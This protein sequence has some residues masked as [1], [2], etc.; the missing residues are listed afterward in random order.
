MSFKGWSFLFLVSSVVAFAD[1]TEARFVSAIQFAVQ[2]ASPELIQRSQGLVRSQFAQNLE[3]LPAFRGMPVEVRTFGNEIVFYLVTPSDVAVPMQYAVSSAIQELTGKVRMRGRSS[4][5][6]AKLAH[7]PAQGG[8]LETVVNDKHSHIV[9]I[10]AQ[11]VPLRDLLKQLKTQL[12]SFSYLIPGD[13]AE[14]RVDLNYGQDS[15]LEKTTPKTIE[16]IMSELASVF[17]LKLEKKND[18]LIFSGACNQAG[19]PRGPSPSAELLT[20]SL[21]VPRPYDSPLMPPTPRQIVF[22]VLPI[23]Q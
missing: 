3:E 5:Y 13:C 12:G 20:A 17:N 7:K 6:L 19:P 22:P 21:E 23:G 15:P 9:S 8:Y 10:R 1:G 14:K 18:T 16:A 2:D 4:I 11:S